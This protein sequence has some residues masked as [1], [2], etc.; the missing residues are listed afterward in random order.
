MPACKEGCRHS[1]GRRSASSRRDGRSSASDPAAAIGASRW[2]LRIEENEDRLHVI[3]F[4][5]RVL[6]HGALGE[7]RHDVALPD[8]EQHE[9]GKDRSAAAAAIC[10]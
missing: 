8:D 5:G 7:T 2:R 3:S 1:G 9:C 10:V 4:A 6:F